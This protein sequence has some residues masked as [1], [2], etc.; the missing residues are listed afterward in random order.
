[1]SAPFYQTLPPPATAPPPT[2]SPQPPFPSVRTA[3]DPIAV[4]RDPKLG[5][6]AF[7]FSPSGG[8]A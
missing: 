3:F 5:C 2:P 8:F 7:S 1:M 6:G 4:R